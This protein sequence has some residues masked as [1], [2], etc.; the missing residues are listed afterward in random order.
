MALAKMYP[1]CLYRLYTSREYAPI[2]LSGIVQTEESLS[3]TT[4][5]DC[6]FVFHLPYKLQGDGGDSLNAIAAGKDIAVNV[7][8]SMPFIASMGM[9]LDFKDNVATLNA[10]YHPPFAIEHRRTAR[11]VPTSA[12]GANVSITDHHVVREL[13]NYERWRSTRVALASP[14]IDRTIRFSAGTTSTNDASLPAALSSSMSDSQNILQ[15][16]DTYLEGLM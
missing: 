9:V 5:L 7:I 3:V 16:N 15:H 14:D 10:I 2:T 11:T 6:T 1:H 8:L 13:E 12:A 4:V